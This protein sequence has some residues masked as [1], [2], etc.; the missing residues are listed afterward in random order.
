MWT[1][2]LE[3][4]IRNSEPNE[5]LVCEWCGSA[6]V[7]VLAW[8]NANTWEYVG[9]GPNE[10]AWCPKCEEEVYLTTLDKWQARMEEDDEE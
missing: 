10:K 5:L 2:Q 6:G 3:E 7:E 1:E 8:V 4:H 9:D